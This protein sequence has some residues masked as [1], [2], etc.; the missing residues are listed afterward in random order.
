M[1]VIPLQVSDQS[2]VNIT[3]IGNRILRNGIGVFTNTGTFPPTAVFSG[4]SSGYT[5][6]GNIITDSTQYGAD[7][8][9]TGNIELEGNIIANNSGGNLRFRVAETLLNPPP[10]QLNNN[11]I[12]APA[13]G[14]FNVE[15]LQPTLVDARRNWWGTNDSA[16]VSQTLRGAEQMAVLPPNRVAVLEIEFSRPEDSR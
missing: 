2:A 12:I 4:L 16:A 9:D 8:L 5:L 13:G 3:L 11:T 7:F 14:G 15:N 6:Q 10:L 1:F